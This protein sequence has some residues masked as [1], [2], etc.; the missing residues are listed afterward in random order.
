MTR[1]SVQDALD[2][3]RDQI[4]HPTQNW[5]H[6]CMSMSRQAWGQ[7][8]WA[9]SANRAWARVPSKHRHH[10]HFSKVP[11]GVI[12]FGL[13]DT[14]WGHAWISGRADAGFSVDYRRDGRIDRVPVNL[15]AWTG[16]E[17]VWWTDWSPFGM[18]PIWEDPRNK[19]MRP[20][21]CK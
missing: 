3:C 12:C 16:D 10:T 4:T 7:A 18:L 13:F 5:D 21:G 8:P 14:T 6:Q 15:P 1:A 2:W 17:K 20:V 11:A 19:G 9:T